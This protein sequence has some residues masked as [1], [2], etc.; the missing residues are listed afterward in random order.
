MNRRDVLKTGL[1]LVAVAATAKNAFA[2]YDP[3]EYTPEAYQ[4]ALDSGEPLLVGFHAEWCSTC[5]TQERAISQ[6][7]KDNEKYASVKVI[8]VDWDVHGRTE[9]AK[10]LRIPRRSTLVMFNGGEEVGRVVAQTASSA[11]E[12]LFKAAL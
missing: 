11:I 3:I 7:M 9:F 4:A 10:A 5:R 2:N 8:S 1:G 12:D 6:L